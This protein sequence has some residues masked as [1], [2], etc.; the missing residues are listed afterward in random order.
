MANGGESHPW[1]LFSTN[2]AFDPPQD[3]IRIMVKEHR[4]WIDIAWNHLSAPLLVVRP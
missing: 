2:W 3:S 1:D 4:L